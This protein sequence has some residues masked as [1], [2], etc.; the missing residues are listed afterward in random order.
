MR[1]KPRNLHDHIV[2]R[3][4]I[5]GFIGFGALAAALSYANYALFFVRHH[6]SA[7]YIDSTL[8]LY[9]QATSLTYLTL[10]LCLYVYLMFE[11]SD[12]H[13]R[14]FSSYLWSNTRLLQAFAVS[15][16]LIGNVLYNPFVQPYFGT[17]ALTLIDWLTAL[18]CAAL[19]MTFRLA[20]RHT[21]KHTRRAVLQLHH[22]LHA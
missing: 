7:R 13:E 22:E 21:R 16:V 15:F 9:H 5:A 2:N 18:G 11:R 3:T 6:L 17:A 4:T 12:A 19:Y 10:V 8:P 14:F 20:Q 1:D